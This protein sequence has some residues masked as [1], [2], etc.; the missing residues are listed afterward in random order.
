MKK[1]I[2]PSTRLLI[3]CAL[4]VSVFSA[5]GIFFWQQRP[6]PPQIDL[7]SLASPLDGLGLAQPASNSLNAGQTTPLPI[8]IW[9]LLDSAAA[10]EFARSELQK[11]FD[12]P[13]YYPKKSI[14]LLK[15]FRIPQLHPAITALFQDINLEKLNKLSGRSNA[16]SFY[17]NILHAVATQRLD[18]EAALLQQK[19]G[20]WEED[21]AEYPDKLTYW[22]MEIASD[23]LRITT[24]AMVALQPSQL[25]RTEVEAT[26]HEHRGQASNY[27]WFA[28]KLN[29]IAAHRI[30]QKQ[31]PASGSHELES[32]YL[33]QVSIPLIDETWQAVERKQWG[34][35]E[36][37]ILALSPEQR[38]P[39]SNALKQTRQ[40]DLPPFQLSSG[41]AY[42]YQQTA[43]IP[44][45]ALGEK[46]ILLIRKGKPAASLLKT[47]LRAI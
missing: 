43:L 25:S 8:D 33:N 20:T 40:R 26:Y 7:T 11:Y 17:A 42:I 15:T 1:P 38:K 16:H 27:V 45:T 21:Y 44:V 46:A 32:F 18:N 28:N 41:Q 19:I 24:M 3:I 9:M 23:C 12:T 6:A 5:T 31:A 37:L 2:T 22:E 14:A 47:S 34:S 36:K 29:Q 13:G 30:Q 35:L 10:T 39:V 4:F